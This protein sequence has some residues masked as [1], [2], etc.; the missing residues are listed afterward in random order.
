VRQVLAIRDAAVEFAGGNLNKRVEVTSKDEIG[1][2]AASF[3]EMATNRERAEAELVERTHQLEVSNKELELFA[4]AASHDLRAPL[5]SIDSFSQFLLEDYAEKL[6]TQGKDYLQR[7]RTASQRMRQLINDLLRLSQVTHSEMC[8]ERVDLSA[9]AREIA[10]ELQRVEPE[11]QVEVIIAEGVAAE[12]DGGLLRVALDNLLGNAWK[13]T[14]KHPRA[15][16]EL[17]VTHD[18]RTHSYFVRDDGAGF[19]MADVDKLFGTF[20]RLHSPSEFGGT[21]IGLAIVQRIVHRHEGRIWAEGTEEQGATF[22]F[23]LN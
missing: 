14:S 10:A 9:L 5:Q 7:V 2:L 22:Y 11:R 6:D 17:G 19:A 1:Q 12:G 15:R 20:Q 13:V 3:N 8:R 23:T 18:N 16:I 4:F 21:G